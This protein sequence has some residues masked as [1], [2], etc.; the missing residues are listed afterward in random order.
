MKKLLGIILATALTT[1][2][3][4]DAFYDFVSSDGIHYFSERPGR[5]LLVA[6]IGIIGGLV[7]FGFSTLSQRLRRRVGLVVLGLGA[8]FVMLG[9]SYLSFQVASF[10]TVV[11]PTTLRLVPATPRH[12]PWLLVLGTLGLA[13]LLWFQFYQLLR[14]RKGVA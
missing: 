3:V 12:I 14:S 8:I 13:A 4:A 7:T 1:L 9:G 5:L 2:A 11:D 6:V 10:Q